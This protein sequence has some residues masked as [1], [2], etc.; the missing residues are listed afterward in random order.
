MLRLL[1][2][3]VFQIAKTHFFLVLLFLAHLLATNF[4]QLQKQTQQLSTNCLYP[5]QSKQYVFFRGFRKYG[6]VVILFNL[7]LKLAHWQSHQKQKVL[8]IF[9]CAFHR[10]FYKICSGTQQSFQSSCIRFGG[11]ALY[12]CYF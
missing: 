10:D 5:S 3:I 6:N 11:E 7:L 8:D 4:H 12:L 1:I 2:S 9:R